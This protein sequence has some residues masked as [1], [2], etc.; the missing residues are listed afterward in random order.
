M[1]V[2]REYRQEKESLKGGIGVLGGTRWS[3]Q[4]SSQNSKVPDFGV[5]MPHGVRLRRKINGV[6]PFFVKF[7]LVFGL[8]IVFGLFWEFLL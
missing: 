8:E 7:R 1:V 2:L 4:I 6:G 5:G 3:C